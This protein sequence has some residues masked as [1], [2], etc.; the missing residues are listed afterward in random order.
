MKQLD[1]P[2]ALI[3]TADTAVNSQQARRVPIVAFS[4]S[5]LRKAIETV[6]DC[7]LGALNTATAV[8][9]DTRA[10]AVQETHHQLV[11]A[12]TAL[13]HSGYGPGT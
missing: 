3:E 5:A 8:A 10:A 4:R 7:V 13:A 1:A 12:A 11:T 9:T 6:H 2:D